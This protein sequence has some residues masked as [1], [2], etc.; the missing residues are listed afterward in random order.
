VDQAQQALDRL[1]GD[2][3]TLTERQRVLRENLTRFDTLRD[4]DQAAVRE[5]QQFLARNGYDPGTTDGRMGSATRAALRAYREATQGE[6]RQTSADLNAMAPNI[7]AAQ[8]ALREATRAAEMEAGGQRLRDLDANTPWYQRAWHTFGPYAGLLLGGFVGY[9]SRAGLGKVRNEI[10]Q[11]AADRADALMDQAGRGAVSS[12]AAR[13]NQFWDEGGGRPVPFER[14][15]GRTPEPWR[16]N[17]E[18]PAH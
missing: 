9:G 13:V 4:S 16:S 12:R 15:P 14:A 1:L 10:S 11:R 5:A 2:R 6:L 8:Q 17:P 7:T 18:A 3:N